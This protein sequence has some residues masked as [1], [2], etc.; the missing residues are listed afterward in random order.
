MCLEMFEKHYTLMLSNTFVFLWY[1]RSTS[2]RMKPI[3][4]TG[5]LGLC[6]RAVFSRFCETQVEFKF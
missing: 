6:S 2:M 4:I 5:V 1:V 3:Y